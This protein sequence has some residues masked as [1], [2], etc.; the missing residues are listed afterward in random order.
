[1]KAYK[2]IFMLFAFLVILTTIVIFYKNIN[3]IKSKNIV[4]INI[5]KEE[6]LQDVN[7]KLLFAGDIFLGRNV[8]EKSLASKSVGDERYNYP[9][10]KLDT[11]DRSAYDAWIGNLECPVTDGK[12]DYRD[13][14]VYLK[15][16]CDKRFLPFMRKYFDIVSLANN[17]TDNMNGV[18]GL[19]E[20]RGNLEKENY[21]YFGN[22]DTSV[23][24]DICEIVEIKKTIDSKEIKIPIAMC[25]YHGVF[26]L[27]TQEQ[28]NI[29]KEYSKYFV[30]V[31]MP[32]QGEEY[33][34]KSGT[35]QKSIYRKF[36][37]AGADVVIGAH[38]HVM[39][40]VEEYKGKLIFYSLGN[41]IF[42]QIDQ[43]TRKHFVVEANLNFKNINLNNYSKF[44]CKKYKDDCLEKA[45]AESMV[46]PEVDIKYDV[47]PTENSLE[48]I[49]Q[50]RNLNEKQMKEFYKFI[51]WDKIK[52]EFKI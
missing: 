14:N 10:Q 12:V 40:E 39:Q 52:G 44:K 6:K 25:G 15:F 45:R 33:K 28:I 9:F 18:K 27:P 24:Q 38:P 22:F 31:V 49:T 32:H 5:I 26:K 48:F 11:L 47:I 16:N 30:T 37:D 46:K 20:T 36:I 7:L 3:K 8:R 19:E 13:E 43:V 17:H 23:K 35:Y 41:F 1:M 34:S 50:K 2:K 29:I 42:D 4:A 21:Q 51:E